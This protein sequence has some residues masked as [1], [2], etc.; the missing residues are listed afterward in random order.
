M[1][2]LKNTDCNRKFSLSTISITLTAP[3][4]H[5]AA[6]VLDVHALGLDDLHDDAVHV[7]QLW[8]GRHGVC[9]DRRGG[10]VRDFTSR[11]PVGGGGVAVPLAADHTGL[12]LAAAHGT[13]ERGTLVPCLLSGAFGWAQLQV[14]VLLTLYGWG[15]GGRKGNGAPE[16]ALTVTGRARGQGGHQAHWTFTLSDQWLHAQLTAAVWAQISVFLV[17]VVGRE[18]RRQLRRFWDR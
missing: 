18:G 7:G 8:V 9:D 11:L 4:L 15:G 17:I 3:H 12:P 14:Y 6:Q 16:K 1:M 2:M 5:D 13:S 10:D